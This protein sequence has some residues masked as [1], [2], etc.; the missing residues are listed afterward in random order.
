MLKGSSLLKDIFMLKTCLHSFDSL[1]ISIVQLRQE[2]SQA[3]YQVHVQ[4]QQS[5]LLA[6]IENGAFVFH[7]V[8]RV[9]YILTCVTT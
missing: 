1:P 6:S 2:H 7:V 9:C 5:M 3:G 8:L 4:T